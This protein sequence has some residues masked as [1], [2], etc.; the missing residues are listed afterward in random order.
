[1]AG[2]VLVSIRRFLLGPEEWRRVRRENKALR[3]AL[4]ATEIER[5]HAELQKLSHVTLELLGQ[6][7][8]VGNALLAA[9]LE[10]ECLEDELARGEPDI[11]LLREIASDLTAAV[12]Q[13]AA[14]VG[15][16]RQLAKQGGSEV[17]KG[18]A[19]ASRDVDYVPIYDMLHDLRASIAH[20]D[21]ERRIAIVAEGGADR[22]RVRCVAGDTTLRRVFEN[23][24]INACQGD[25]ERRA[26]AIN[27]R[28]LETADPEWL[29]IKV[30]DDGPGFPQSIIS[31][32]VHGL[33]TTKPDGTGIGLFTS[34]RLVTV[35]GGTLS[36]ANA[37]EGGAMVTVRLPRDLG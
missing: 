22:A 2:Q 12:D 32:G 13:I 35:C 28:I 34:E 5:K 3:E 25:G 27:V 8:D 36:I 31:D 23:L 6:L 15:H 10:T 4:L 16:V 1:M 19:R 24:L 14:T 37:H 7:H 30:A 26:Q 18:H 33:M 29:E 9:K 17:A 21:R 11:P 20:R